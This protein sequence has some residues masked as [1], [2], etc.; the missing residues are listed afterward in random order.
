[1][2]LRWAPWKY[3]SEA[4]I[5][6]KP[7]KAWISSPPP[8]GCTFDPAIS[9]FMSRNLLAKVVDH[10]GLEKRW[11]VDKET[12][13]RIL[14][15]SVTSQNVSGTDLTSIRV[16]HANKQDADDIAREVA[17]SCKTQLEEND[18]RDAEWTLQKLKKDVRDQEEK[19]EERRKILAQIARTDSLIHRG[20]DSFYGKIGR[21]KNHGDNNE[22]RDEA[23]KRNLDAQDY[24]DAI[25]DFEADQKLLH[26]M[27]LKLITATF[28]SEDPCA[29]VVIIKQPPGHNGK[30]NDT[31]SMALASKSDGKAVAPTADSIPNDREAP[32]L[33]RSSAPTTPPMAPTAPQASL[34]PDHLPQS[35]DIKKADTASLSAQNLAQDRQSELRKNTDN[36][37]PE[38]VSTP[39]KAAIQ[40]AVMRDPTLDR[41]SHVELFS[42]GEISLG[43]VIFQGNKDYKEIL[44]RP[45]ALADFQKVFQTG[46]P[47]AKC[48]ALVGI[49]AIE[50]K[51]FMKLASSLH[52][53]K[54]E[55]A[56]QAGCIATHKSLVSILKEMGAENY[57][58]TPK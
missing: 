32:T 20:E 35:S 6:V 3:T 4:I 7:L 26:T 57:D 31:E 10:L 56:T 29:S 24:V 19:V 36:K 37:K 58:L 45:T 5:E 23:I 11:N 41:L 43:G 50:P 16:R 33:G 13:L 49:R 25:K 42:F 54:T 21:D 28:S 44:L 27:K 53:D 15:A 39:N 18:S 8:S 17:N 12:A 38:N 2:A 22:D 9:I 30:H 55:V 47:E 51:I 48:Y 14:K 1:V 52:S 40:A 46:T 34:A